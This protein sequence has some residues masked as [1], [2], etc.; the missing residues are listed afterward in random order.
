MF[1]KSIHLPAFENAEFIWRAKMYPININ[2]VDP[3]HNRRNH[4]IPAGTHV[5]SNRMTSEVLP[6]IPLAVVMTMAVFMVDPS[7]VYPRKQDRWNTQARL[8][9]WKYRVRSSDDDP[10]TVRKAI[11]WRHKVVAFALTFSYPVFGAFRMHGTPEFIFLAVMPYFFDS[12]GDKTNK[13]DTKLKKK[14][15]SKVITNFKSFVLLIK[16]SRLQHFHSI[17][18]KQCLYL[19][20]TETGFVNK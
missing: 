15:C 7:V 5:G 6:I 18:Q 1:I 19:Q 12:Y 10:N 20:S 2:P 9:C 11:S 3:E 4:N 16:F 17:T 14:T 13:T 8:M